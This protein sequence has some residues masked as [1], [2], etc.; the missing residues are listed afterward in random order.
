MTELEK[1]Q[2]LQ[3]QRNIDFIAD[4]INEATG[5]SNPLN[6]LGIRNPLNSQNS[7]NLQTPSPSQIFI[8]NKDPNF[9]P[10][11]NL[12][13]NIR[14]VLDPS[15]KLSTF[16]PVAVEQGLTGT[17]KST[18]QRT[19]G[20]VDKV[21]D[22]PVP[23]PEEW[24]TDTKQRDLPCPNCT[25]TFLVKYAGRVFSSIATFLKNCFNIRVEIVQTVKDY[26]IERLPVSKRVAF[27]DGKCP[28]CE[29]KGTV[30]DPSDDRA[31]YVESAGIAQGYTQEIEEN[32]AKLGTGG[33]R[34]TI[35]Q[36]HEVKEV[37]L[38]MNDVDS[39]RIDY[40]KGYRHWG[41]AGWSK[42]G[43][44][45]KYGPIPRGSKKNH[46]QGTNPIASPGG[47]YTIKCSN[48]FSLLT[49][50]LG[51]E[52]V[53]G[54]P[55]TIKGG[56]TRITGPE[57]TIGTQTGTL[58]LEGEVINMK[59]KS[60]EVTPT[61]GHF[62]VKGTIS[63]SGNL[64]VGGH[65]HLESASVVK[66]ETVGRNEPSKVSSSNNLYSGPAFWGGL[67][68][69]GA[70]AAAEELLAYVSSHTINPELAKNIASPRFAAGILDNI[71]NIIYTSLP[72]ELV[73]TGYVEVGGVKLPVFNYPHVHAQFDQQ[74]Y[75]ETRIPDIDCTA[76]T[77]QELRARQSGVEG[78]APIH[79]K[80]TSLVDVAKVVLAPIGYV[81]IKPWI[82]L[83]KNIQK[84]FV[85]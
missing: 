18:S 41:L 46:I 63:N 5:V 9:E 39:Y 52:L 13:T 83:S 49:G 21:S 53:T 48:K 2:L 25:G 79:K 57:V 22:R 58:G 76:D 66:L 42:G 59:G 8:G 16:I 73:S 17:K 61:D 43:V 36:N 72:Q 38:G 34:Y 6:S 56:Q 81:F 3:Q 35:I 11:F 19:S 65:G 54:G 67:A 71:T 40:D 20:G 31:K 60:I 68:V 84:K 27:Q 64:L 4:Q 45:P 62:F 69:E 78:P 77:A 44:N 70:R 14:P 82:E 10:G 51:I 24:T 1:L 80:S 47:Q 29:G 75:H 74:H 12:S 23:L 37:G 28:Y 85:A 26:I 55:I 7:F 50:A 33:N 32:E 15:G 30:T